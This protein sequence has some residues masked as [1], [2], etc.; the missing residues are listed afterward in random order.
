[1]NVISGKEKEKEKEHDSEENSGTN[2]VL[3]RFSPRKYNLTL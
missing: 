2:N 3:P 1:M